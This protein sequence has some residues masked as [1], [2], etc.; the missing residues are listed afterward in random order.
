MKQTVSSAISQSCYSSHVELDDIWDLR[1]EKSVEWGLEGLWN[2]AIHLVTTQQHY[3]TGLEDL[4]FI[5]LEQ[6]DRNGLLQEYYSKVPL[7]LMHVC[8]VVQ[9]MVNRWEPGFEGMGKLFGFR[10]VANL[11]LSV[12]ETSEGEID[13]FGMEGLNSVLADTQLNCTQCGELLQIESWHDLE[14]FV[15]DVSIRCKTC[16]AMDEQLAVLDRLSHTD[17]DDEVDG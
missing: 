17:D 1:F 11:E 5:F 2:Q 10:V 7:A 13:A 15:R 9:A 6:S 3:P 16:G 8:G 4:N 14:D 12:R